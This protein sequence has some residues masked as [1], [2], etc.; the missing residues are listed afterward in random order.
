M[1]EKVPRIDVF[2][3]AHFGIGL[4]WRR[5]IFFRGFELSLAMP[6]CCVIVGVGPRHEVR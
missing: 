6:F 1:P 3:D 5:S 2:F 4:R